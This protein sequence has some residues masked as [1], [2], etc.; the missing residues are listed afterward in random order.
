VEEFSVNGL[1]V[2]LKPNPANE[3]ISAQLYLRGGALN[4]SEETRGIEPLI[5]NCALRG[6]KNYTKEAINRVLDKTAAQ[7]TAAA[8]RDFTSVDLRCIQRY[9]DET[10]DVFADVIM[11]P[12][13]PAEEVELVRN[14]T[15]DGVRQRK[16]DPDTYL[17]D[18]AAE[19]FYDGHPY[20]L[21]PRG[22]EQSI[23]NISITE[24][25]HYLQEQLVSSKLLLVVVG[26]VS[27][28]DLQKKVEETF[29][30]LQ[31]GDYQPQFPEAVK[32][33]AANLR[34]EERELPTNY[35][36]GYFSAPGLNHPDYYPMVITMN[37]LRSRVWEEVRT[38]RNLSYAPGA[39][40]SSE[41]ANRAAI[42]VTAVDPDTTIKVMLAELKKLQQEPVTEK[43]L[44]DRVTMYLTR[45]YLNNETNAA[46][47]Q[48]LARYELSGRGWP[49]G[50]QFVDNLRKVSAADVQRVAQQYFHNLQFAVLGNPELINQQL[51]TSM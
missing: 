13:F 5:F 26:N 34:V 32:H 4:L 17:R 35:I 33:S 24:M 19:L 39:F 16:D 50:R 25:Q 29:G 47:G 43:D 38:K 41:F 22:T 48:F 9:F 6:S 8:N 14:Q 1:R 40:Y 46:Q 31:P 2:I 20:R 36:I 49:A 44:H 27:K 7:I 42:Y 15:L 28:A 18:I 45:Y 51:F 12:T 21:D 3:I 11:H 23:A 10:W 30:T 37:I